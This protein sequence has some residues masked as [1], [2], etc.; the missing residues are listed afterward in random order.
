MTLTL[1]QLKALVDDA[2]KKEGSNAAF[3]PVH[4]TNEDY[5]N[6]GRGAVG[7]MLVRAQ[8][9]AFVIREEVYE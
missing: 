9:T 5:A 7:A 3:I 2:V 6:T 8:G 1:T 4:V